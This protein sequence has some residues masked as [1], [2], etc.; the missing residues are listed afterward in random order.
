MIFTI[1]IKG[2]RMR[3]ALQLDA[4]PDLPAVLEHVA[5]LTRFG[6]VDVCLD[7]GQ[8]RIIL[9]T[10]QES[11]RASTVDGALVRKALP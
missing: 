3:G 10:L 1:R 11:A 2:P 4:L 5:P 6:R 7:V 9:A 8:V